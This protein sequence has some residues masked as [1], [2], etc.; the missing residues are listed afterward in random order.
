MKSHAEIHLQRRYHAR[1]ASAYDQAHL[2]G[3]ESH[4]LAIPTLT[5]LMERYD[6]QSVLDVDSRTGRALRHFGQ[7]LPDRKI[8]GTEPVA[9]R[10]KAGHQRFRS[11]QPR[12]LIPG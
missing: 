9:V 11:C 2:H 6:F 1:T 12:R 7:R 5:A 3:E 8:R 4:E 10:R